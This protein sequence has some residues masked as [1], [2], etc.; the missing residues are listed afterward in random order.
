MDEASIAIAIS[1]ATIA[2]E[3]NFAKSA[4]KAGLETVDEEATAYDTEA[5]YESDRTKYAR[6]QV[7][8]FKRD[9]AKR[10]ESQREGLRQAGIDEE[11]VFAS[12]Y[13]F[14][15]REIAYKILPKEV[16]LEGLSPYEQ[17][18]LSDYRSKV[19][20]GFAL[21]VAPLGINKVLGAAKSVVGKIAGEIGGRGMPKVPKV[22]ARST[23]SSTLGK[24][25]KAEAMPAGSKLEYLGPGK[26]KFDGVEFRAV[27]DLGHLSERD[28]QRMVMDGVNPKDVKG[29][30]LDGHH[31]G[32][33]YH[34]EKGA[35]M[36]EIPDPK[37]CI[38]NPVQ[39]PLGTSGG[40]TVE[41]RADWKKLRVAFNKEH[42]RAELLRR[43]SNE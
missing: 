15:E 43:G 25:I 9:Q 3:N 30:R 41:Q 40:L 38:S 19:A 20:F 12:A 31:H 2:V 37:H 17:Q 32:Q 39:H 21:E 26:V 33:Q 16:G 14:K 11:S 27:R 18:V 28:L 10:N 13:A 22:A 36:V 42:A 29:I 1:T 8:D 5:G 24:A 7:E 23:A 6:E 35:F 4:E 34:R